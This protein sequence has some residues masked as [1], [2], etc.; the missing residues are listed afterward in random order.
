MKIRLK[1]NVPRYARLTEGIVVEAEPVASHPELMRVKGF[2]AFENGALVQSWE[3]VL[4][5]ED[6]EAL[7]N[8]G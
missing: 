2:G 5:D 8:E 7:L 6:L 3:L 4:L 1:Q